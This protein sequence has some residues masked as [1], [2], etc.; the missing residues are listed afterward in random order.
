MPSHVS[1]VADSAAISPNG[2]LLRLDGLRWW[3]AFL[4]F[5]SHAIPKDY[6]W[7]VQ[8]G[9]YAVLFFFVLSGFVIT[10]SMQYS[11]VSVGDGRGML[12]W[13]VVFIRKRVFRIL[14]PFLMVMLSIQLFVPEA[15]GPNAWE[16]WLFLANM[17]M[18]WHEVMHPASAHLWSVAVEEQF[19]LVWP[20]LFAFGHWMYHRSGSL[21]KYFFLLVCCGVVIRLLGYGGLFP[22]MYR[23]QAMPMVFEALMV[24]ALMT[25]VKP[26]ENL[27]S[28]RVLMSVAILAFLFG[29]LSGP[30]GLSQL[31]RFASKELCYQAVIL[32]SACCIIRSG[33]GEVGWKLD[34]ALLNAPVQYGGQFSYGFYLYHVPLLYLIQSQWPMH[35]ILTAL[36][37]LLL[38]ICVSIGSFECI[39][40]PLM[41]WNQKAMAVRPAGSSRQ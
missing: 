32:M 21:R 40:R 25:T 8:W 34:G 13:W 30:L 16:Y 23:E 3:A 18:F 4:V 17:S 6:Q 15:L 20:S 31:S 12:R 9:T 33:A 28:A 14:P 35:W 10:R 41:R 22:S 7:G 26:Y 24:G 19:Y 5:L 2:R 37:T 29:A 27:G 39:E 1:E 11:W 36:L 38:S